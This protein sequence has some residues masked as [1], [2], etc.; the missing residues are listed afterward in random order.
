[1]KNIIFLF[2]IL[3]V[4]HIS[5]SRNAQTLIVNQPNFSNSLGDT[6][7]QNGVAHNVNTYTENE[8]LII[9][10]SSLEDS[11]VL[12]KVTQKVQGDLIYKPLHVPS[13]TVKMH[14]TNPMNKKYISEGLSHGHDYEGVL[15]IGETMQGEY[16]LNF[17]FQKTGIILYPDNDF[18]MLDG[19][20][21]IQLEVNYHANGER[22]SIITSPLV[23][24]HTVNKEIKKE[25]ERLKNK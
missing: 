20:Y 6:I 10:I 17:D 19:S 8:H 7:I 13:P 22:Q 25:I 1:M 3:L 9:S 15:G 16:D 21:Q 2:Y 18:F 14:L 24:Q 4:F 11:N 5:C 23:Y 12:C